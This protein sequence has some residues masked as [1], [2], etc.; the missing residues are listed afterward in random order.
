MWHRFKENV[1]G[2]TNRPQAGGL[3]LG[4]WAVVLQNRAAA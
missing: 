4:N 2:K 1:N 3:Y